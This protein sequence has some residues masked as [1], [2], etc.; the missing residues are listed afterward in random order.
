M[1]AA[2]LEAKRLDKI[3]AAH[4]EDMALVNGGCI[5]AGDYARAHGLP[6]ICSES[7]WRQVERDL[8]LA[9]ETGCKYHVCHVSTKE[10]VALIRAAKARGVDVSC[11]T[12]PHYLVLDDSCLQDDGRFKMNPPLRAKEDREALLAGPA[13]R[14][15]GHG[16]HRPRSHSAAEKS[17]GLR[18]SLMGAVGLETAFP[19]LYTRIC[20]YGH[21]AA[22][23]ALL[24]TCRQS[25]RAFGF[26]DENDWTVF[27][28][29]SVYTVD[30]ETFLSKGRATPFAG[31]SV[32][33][34]CLMTIVGGKIVWKNA[35]IAN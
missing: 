19:V 8:R 4:C 25:R 5:H 23:R 16:R 17:R 7:E 9:E 21:I 28:L 11:E 18:A 1:R 35:S 13:R 34:E 10:S 15:G 31:M 26:D 6:G 33:G 12:G 14:H 24:S 2:M 20:A 27:D 30:P 22:G 29:D 3:I 32:Y